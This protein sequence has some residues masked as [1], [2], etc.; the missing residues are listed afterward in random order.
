MQTGEV[1]GAVCSLL[2]GEGLLE[3]PGDYGQ[4]ASFIVGG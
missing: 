2:L 4:V 3:Q 1:S